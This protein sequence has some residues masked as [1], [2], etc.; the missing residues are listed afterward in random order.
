ME[1]NSKQSSNAKSLRNSDSDSIVGTSRPIPNKNSRDSSKESANINNQWETPKKEKDNNNSDKSNQD[2][3]ID[4]NFIED[5]SISQE[6]I[7]QDNIED[8]KE[9]LAD[10]ESDSIKENESPEFSI[11]KNIKNFYKNLEIELKKVST[12][13]NNNNEI[14]EKE[15]KKLDQC[16]DQFKDPKAKRASLQFVEKIKMLEELQNKNIHALMQENKKMPAK[17]S[18]KEK[19][20]KNNKRRIK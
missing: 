16:K 15:T 13:N 7:I 20:K 18:I 10:D 8:E 11:D 1:F 4:D 17:K 6:E 2:E 9:D 14:K 5:S 3:I 12:K 19:P